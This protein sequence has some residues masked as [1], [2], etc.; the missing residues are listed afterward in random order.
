MKKVKWSF[1]TGHEF[2]KEDP[3]CVKEI[4]DSD[5]EPFSLVTREIVSS[6]KNST[7]LKCPAHT[8]FLKN[9]YVLKAPFDI[10]FDIN[11]VEEGP[12][13]VYCENISQEVFD[14]VIDLRFL[15][16][17][18][19][20]ISH[21]PVIGID[22]LN[23]FRS[24]ESLMMQVF[25]AFL[26]YNDFTYK[27]CVIPGEFDISK[28]VRPVEL[29]FEVKTRKEKIEI[30]KGD[31]LAYFKFNS[32]DIIKLEKEEVP[33]DSIHVCS[34]LRNVKPFR[35]LKERYAAFNEHKNNESNN[36]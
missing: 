25:P 11:V 30:K 4:I 14:Y 1:G 22:F 35:P 7:F 27:T 23:T 8:D 33:W 10:T 2:F 19:R 31:A 16:N 34:N 12:S 5:Y 24:E 21:H 15:E 28:W 29:V 13:T 26:H 32:E 9:T 18:E 20:G 3:I 36:G 6:R 17:V